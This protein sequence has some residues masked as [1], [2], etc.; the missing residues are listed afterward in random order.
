[1]ESKYHGLKVAAY[2]AEKPCKVEEAEFVG[3]A[4][5]VWQPGSS[6]FPEVL[7]IGT[8]EGEVTLG[9]GVVDSYWTILRKDPMTDELCVYGRAPECLVLDIVP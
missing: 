9:R 7:N 6:P 3:H 1:M 5:Q 8:E 2:R 4:M